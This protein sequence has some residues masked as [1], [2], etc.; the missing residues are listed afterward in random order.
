ME[1]MD[2]GLSGDTAGDFHSAEQ[3]KNRNHIE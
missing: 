1:E 3:I 2:Q